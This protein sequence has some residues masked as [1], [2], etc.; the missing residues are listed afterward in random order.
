LYGTYTRSL[1]SVAAGKWL[2][3]ALL[4]PQS[5]R[6]RRGRGNREFTLAFKT[7]IYDINVS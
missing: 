7:A 1:K 3:L 6:E 4:L 5:G 2:A